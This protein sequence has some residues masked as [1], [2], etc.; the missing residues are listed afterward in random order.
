MQQDLFRYLNFTEGLLQ[1]GRPSPPQ[2][3]R[4]QNV[5]LTLNPTSPK[6]SL[7]MR[8]WLFP[9]FQALLPMQSHAIFPFFSPKPDPTGAGHEGKVR[10]SRAKPMLPVLQGRF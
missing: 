6:H 8:N 2:T 9:H 7:C 10:L 5:P 1:I 3:S 4:M